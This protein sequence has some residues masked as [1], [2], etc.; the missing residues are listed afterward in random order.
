[1]VYP[2]QN[3]GGSLI[4]NV[5]A[6]ALFGVITIQTRL[7]F[8]RFPADLLWIKTM[9]A[10]FWVAQFVDV[11]LTSRGVYWRAIQEY[12]G[13][14]SQIPQSTW[15]VDHWGI[16]VPVAA[17]FVQTFFL[18]R[19]WTLSRQRLYS[20]VVSGLI[21]A[22]AIL[23]LYSASYVYVSNGTRAVP[24]KMLV[25]YASISVG[26][27][28][29]LT[30]GVTLALRKH[31]TGFHQTDR[32]LNWIIFYGVA[33]GALT[34][35][36][37]MVMLLCTVTGHRKVLSVTMVPYG[38]V[39]ITS[40]LAHLHSRSALRTQLAGELRLTT[41]ALSSLKTS[42]LPKPSQPSTGRPVLDERG[43]GSQLGGS[44]LTVIMEATAP[45]RPPSAL[46]PS[47]LPNNVIGLDDIVEVAAEGAHGIAAP[48][49]SPTPTSSFQLSGATPNT[50]PG[51]HPRPSGSEATAV[52]RPP[53]FNPSELFSKRRRRS[54]SHEFWT[55]TPMPRVWESV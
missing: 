12:N 24:Y 42:S 17:V 10:F 46:N 2:L 19:L 43:D 51:Y 16:D 36:F 35:C 6:S 32:I 45:S 11:A 26:I 25:E 37:A 7:Y 5:L 18:Y 44:P 40:A 47:D 48:S 50:E 31:C 9:V 54:R 23:G 14:L 3:I 30:F 8:A 22:N 4:G 13:Q 39:Y 33:T 49:S 15:N 27:D 21:I 52:R 20:L 28:V 53:S 34:S 41:N 29:A 1:M 55:S 38:G